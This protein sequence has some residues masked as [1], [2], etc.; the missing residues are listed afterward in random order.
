ME[1][2]DWLQDF[3]FS[4]QGAPALLFSA[5]KEKPEKTLGDHPDSKEV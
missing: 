5:A 2:M 1:P 3:D 4:I